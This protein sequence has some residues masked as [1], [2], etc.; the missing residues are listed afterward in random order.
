MLR[1]IQEMYSAPLSLPG[2]R[3]SP[4]VIPNVNEAF[5]SSL[6]AS[7]PD[8]PN[9]EY[10]ETRRPRSTSTV[11]RKIIKQCDPVAE[12]RVADGFSS[13]VTVSVPGDMSHEYWRRTGETVLTNPGDADGEGYLYLFKWDMKD[14]DEVGVETF[15]V[16]RWG[17]TEDLAKLYTMTRAI[18]IIRRIQR[19][20]LEV[21]SGTPQLHSTGV[22]NATSSDEN[23]SPIHSCPVLNLGARLHNEWHSNAKTYFALSPPSTALQTLTDL[24][25]SPPASTPPS[26]SD[27][28]YYYKVCLR[29]IT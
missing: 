1:Y 3:F 7:F 24:V 12:W 28:L 20:V 25:N 6:T 4:T 8:I 27:L 5:P 26:I 13:T 23:T 9:F 16:K 22:N 17:S 18:D 11:A 10:H 19:R 21:E 15:Q 29:C 2:T 14:K